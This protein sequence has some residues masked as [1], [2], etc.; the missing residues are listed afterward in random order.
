MLKHS[1]HIE[2]VR[3]HLAQDLKLLSLDDL[4]VPRDIDV[5]VFEKLDGEDFLCFTRRPCQDSCQ[6]RIVD[7]R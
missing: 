6:K 1:A 2:R 3:I 4:L 5:S 7:E